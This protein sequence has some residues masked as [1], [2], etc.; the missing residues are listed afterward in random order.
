MQAHTRAHQ[1]CDQSRVMKERCSTDL[2]QEKADTVPLTAQ[3][4]LLTVNEQL[5]RAAS[6]HDKAEP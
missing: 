1:M 2:L 5:R 6:S 4:T 3:S